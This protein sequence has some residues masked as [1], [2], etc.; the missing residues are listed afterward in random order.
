MTNSAVPV[1]VFG[2]GVVAVSLGLY[3]TCALTGA[4]GVTCWGSNYFG[5]L[6]DGSSIQG[7]SVVPVGVAGLGSG[8][9]TIGA[10]NY[11][12]CALTT[13]GGVKCWGYNGA[14]QL[15]NDPNLYSY[16]LVPVDVT[17]FP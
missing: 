15:G 5:T 13:A 1:D 11:H 3:H 2:S 14:G 17:G 7:A 9:V 6:G 8:V 16:S 4:G 10:N 12:N